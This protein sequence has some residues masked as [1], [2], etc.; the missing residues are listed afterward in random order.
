MQVKTFETKKEMGKAAAKE[1]AKILRGTIK[2]KGEAAFVVAT[3]ASQFEFLKALT[4]ISSI[5]WSKTTMFHL[6]EYIGIPEN[7]PA[8]FRKYLKEKLINKV[9]PGTVYLIKGAL[10]KA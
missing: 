9:H 1:A 7:D 2:E 4:S 8:S 5:D 10:P 3:G 6:D